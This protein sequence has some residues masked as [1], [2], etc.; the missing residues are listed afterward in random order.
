MYGEVFAGGG[1]TSLLD[2]GEYLIFTY[3]LDSS[4]IMKIDDVLPYE[5]SARLRTL[6]FLYRVKPS[7][8]SMSITNTS[9]TTTIYIYGI[10][11]D[12]TT[13]L[14]DDSVASGATKTVQ[15]SGYDYVNVNIA[16]AANRKEVITIT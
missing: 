14:S 5:T 10:N 6:E 9:G 11:G 3:D 15:I 16:V 1:G 2:L 4:N 13:K 12:V 8:T 7:D